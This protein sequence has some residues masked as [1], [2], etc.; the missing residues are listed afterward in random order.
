MVISDGHERD[1]GSVCCG[2]QGIPDVRGSTVL[3][4]TDGPPVAQMIPQYSTA[5]IAKDAKIGTVGT[6]PQPRNLKRPGGG[7]LILGLE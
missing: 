4:T 2:Q 7:V 6:I 3:G 5:K 1:R